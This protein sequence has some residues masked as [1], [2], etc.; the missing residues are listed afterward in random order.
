MVTANGTRNVVIEGFCSSSWIAANAPDAAF[1]ISD[2]EGCEAVLF[3]PLVV[4]QLRS[5]TLII[6]THDG[7][8]PGVSDALQ[9]LFS[10]TH[11]IRMYGHDGSRRASTRVLDFLTDRER[12]LATQEARTPQ[13]WLLC[14]PK[15]GPNRA[16]HRAVG[17]R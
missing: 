2:C 10:R 12:Q 1:V 7:L 3:D 8:V 11:D 4:A 6:E 5:A 14:L 16:L 9:T 13:L 17:E 15:T